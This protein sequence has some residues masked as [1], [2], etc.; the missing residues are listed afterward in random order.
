MSGLFG[1]D[2]DF[3]NQV[4]GILDPI[5]SNQ[6]LFNGLK[7][8]LLIY[9]SLAA[10]R[11]PPSFAPYLASTYARIAIMAFIIWIWNKDPGVAIAVAVVYYLTLHYLMQNSLQQVADTGLVSEDVSVLVS[12][13]NGPTIKPA[14][15]VLAEKQ[16]MQQSVNA[17]GHAPQ[18][19][20]ATGPSTPGFV[21]VPTV[22]SGT[23]SNVPS[24][25]DV[26]AG[27]SVPQ[28]TVPDHVQ[29]LAAAP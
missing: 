20:L 26:S 12:G 19:M 22:P 11:L 15:V 8:I 3:N 5:Y 25:M 24:M 6:I 14:S 29:N 16:M 17:S 9:G 28:A 18:A 7:M 4:N 23:P 10:P 1:S 13:A 27:S 2:F 21:T